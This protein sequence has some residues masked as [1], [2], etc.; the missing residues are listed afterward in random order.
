MKE[1]LL[2]EYKKN[3]PAFMEEKMNDLSH[4]LKNT[5]PKG[6]STI[7]INSL[8]RAKNMYGNVPKYSVE[9]LSTIF[10][11]YQKC[12]VEINKYKK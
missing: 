1:D 9:E 7:E 6:L 11:Y 4:A 5:N 10:E 3:L 12:I 8:I 2:I